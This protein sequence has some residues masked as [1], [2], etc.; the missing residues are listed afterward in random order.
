MARVIGVKI[1]N[2][3]AATPGG[4]VSY[5]GDSKVGAV[6]VLMAI[7]V[8]LDLLRH[9]SLDITRQRFVAYLGA[10]FIFVVLANFAPD[11]AVAL[12]WGIVILQAL[13]LA[14]QIKTWIDGLTAQLGSPAGHD[15]RGGF[16][17][18]LRS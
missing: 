1:P 14:P 3:R 18:A 17:P 15:V 12:L 11:L 9:G 8:G 16:T 10:A 4:F 7:I 5:A 2:A 6:V 13:N